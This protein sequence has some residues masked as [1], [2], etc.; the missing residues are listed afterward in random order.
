MQNQGATWIALFVGF[1]LSLFVCL[2]GCNLRNFFLQQ[3]AA[4]K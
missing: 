1:L 3:N 4:L 2:F